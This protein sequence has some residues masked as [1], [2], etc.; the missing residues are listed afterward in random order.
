MR[1]KRKLRV[2]TSL[3]PVPSSLTSDSGACGRDTLK[4]ETCEPFSDAT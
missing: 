2:E 4:E 3:F 1:A